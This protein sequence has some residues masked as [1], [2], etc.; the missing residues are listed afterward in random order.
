MKRIVLSASV[1]AVSVSGVFAQGGDFTGR[2]D[3]KSAKTGFFA[4]YNDLPTIFAPQPQVSMDKD[5]PTTFYIS[6]AESNTTDD[7]TGT[8]GGGRYPMNS[9]YLPIDSGITS[10]SVTLRPYIGFSDY[11]DISGSYTEVNATAPGAVLRVDSITIVI[12]HK[13]SSGQPNRLYASLTGAQNGN[14][15]TLGQLSYPNNTVYF[16][17]S[18]VTT[19]SLSPSGSPFGANSTYTWDM[20]PNYQHT[21]STGHICIKFDGFTNPGDTLA[22]TG[23]YMEDAGELLPPAIYN[24]FA[25]FSDS[26]GSIFVLGINWYI[27]SKVTYTSLANISNL[28]NNGFAIHSFMPNPANQST[29]LRFELKEASDVA[30]YVTDMTGKQVAMISLPGQNAGTQNYELNT[31]DF[32]SGFYNV[33][34]KVNNMVHTQKLSVVK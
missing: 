15:G 24:S 3:A 17:D 11:A 30:F 16:R 20:A 5:G 8:L 21:L 9:G 32:A 14:F 31:A 12:G 18:I 13:N 4:P 27:I 33:T 25:R 19:T 34:M 1:L 28:D 7:Q 26:P 22:I 10:A 6:Y 2:T 23:L 29:T